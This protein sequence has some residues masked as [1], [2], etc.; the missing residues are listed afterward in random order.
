MMAIIGR[1]QA[2]PEQRGREWLVIADDDTLL[3]Y[4]KGLVS[5]GRFAAASLHSVFAL[6]KFLAQ[7]STQFVLSGLLLHSHAS[8]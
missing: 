1:F 6:N 8:I 5:F 2:S 7:G 4:A 3:R